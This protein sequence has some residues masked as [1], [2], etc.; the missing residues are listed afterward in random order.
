MEKSVL[1]EYLGDSPEMRIID[2]LIE[3]KS[4]DFSKKQMIEGT[5]MGKATFYAHFEKLERLGIVKVARQF[6]KAKLYKLNEANPAAQHLIKMELALIESV[7]PRKMMIKV[8]ATK[9]RNEPAIKII[10]KEGSY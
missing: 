10:H 8:K 9:L 1:L 3:N 4:F 2:F 7:A 5:Q 6:G